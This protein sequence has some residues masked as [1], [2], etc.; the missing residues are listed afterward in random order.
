MLMGVGR[1]N[2][3]TNNVPSSAVINDSEC[4]YDTT[5]LEPS[6]IKESAISSITSSDI[7]ENTTLEIQY[8]SAINKKD[9]VTTNSKEKGASSSSSVECSPFIDTP[10]EACESSTKKANS[11]STPIDES[12]YPGIG[13]PPADLMVVNTNGFNPLQHAALR[14]NPG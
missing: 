8:A 11:V 12:M 14:G 7:T 9:R 4:I 6:C 13:S 1:E 10:S 2:M 3:D 5:S